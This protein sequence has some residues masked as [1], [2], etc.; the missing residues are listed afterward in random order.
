MQSAPVAETFFSFSFTH[1]IYFGNKLIAAFISCIAYVG[2]PKNINITTDPHLK[3]RK[4]PYPSHSMFS[5]LRCS[6]LPAFP[7]ALHPT[8]TTPSPNN[9]I[10]L[11]ILDAI[12]LIFYSDMPVIRICHG[13]TSLFY[14]LTF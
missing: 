2:Y 14:I 13:K 6:Y 11:F 8:N 5:P 7:P 10:G 12:F 1:G 3:R 4:I 9:I